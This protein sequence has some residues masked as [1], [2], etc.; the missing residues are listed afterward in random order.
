[1]PLLAAGTLSAASLSTQAA[2]F[3]PVTTRATAA[4]RVAD[5]PNY[6]HSLQDVGKTYDWSGLDSMKWLDAGVSS[7]FRYEIREND[8]RTPGLVS[9]D[10]LVTQ[11]LVYL[12]IKD[13]VDP[14]RFAGEFQ[15]SRRLW[16]ERLPN[17]NEENF[18]EVL[19]AHLDLHFKD[20]LDGESFTFMTGR[21][22]FDAV[23]RRLIARN[24]FR[25][26]INSFDGFRA[27]LG[28]E[29]SRWEVDAFAL[30]PVNRDV[31][32]FDEPDNN[33]W[34]YGMT[35]YWRAG[36][37]EVEVEPFWLLLQQGSPAGGVLLRDLHTF[38]FHA[39]GQWQEGLWDYDASFAGQLGEARG[40]DV[41]AGAAHAEV[42]R[43]WKTSWKPRLSLWINYASGDQDPTDGV[44]QRFDPLYGATFGFY[45][46]SGYFAWQNLIDP[47]V[48]VG[49]EALPKLRTE[50][51]FRTFWLASDR[52]A[53]VRGLR[54]DPSGNAG[55]FIGQE[56][57][58]RVNYPL[59]KWL[60]LE[61]VYAHF[62]PGAFVA[63]TGANPGS[64]FIYL[65]AI[66]RL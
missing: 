30:R 29:R 3:R 10:A 1:M 47:A 53:W 50:I 55:S 65:Q 62:F 23:D 12:G 16:N 66:L 42:G 32:D 35:G 24:R 15:D 33:A 9:D 57:D 45:G 26:V 31:D 22:T 11:T 39:F 43:S 58:L 46:F 52:D 21:M 63:N 4:D 6:A 20:V 40:R 38:G 61:V 2:E 18:T 51:I 25:N 49:F 13:V 54:V 17:P 34:L 7:R 60:E 14:F 44:S 19:Q 5:R 37:P 36:S 28:D 27:R 59:K 41:A 48:R 64:D 8:Y 56:L